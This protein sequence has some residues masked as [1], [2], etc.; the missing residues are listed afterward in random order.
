MS[1]D[2]ARKNVN[3]ER[4]AWS[5][6]TRRPE[7]GPYGASNVANAFALSLSEDILPRLRDRHTGESVSAQETKRQTTRRSE[8]FEWALAQSPIRVRTRE[9]PVTREASHPFEAN[10]AVPSDTAEPNGVLT[11]DTSSDRLAELRARDVERLLFALLRQ[12][13]LWHDTLD[14]LVRRWGSRSAI[15]DHILVPTAHLLGE[16]WCD[17]TASIV[18][19]TIGLE[20]LTRALDLLPNAAFDGRGAKALLVPT[21]GETHRFGLDILAESLRED[22]WACTVMPSGDVGRTTRMLHR[23]KPDVVGI[24]LSVPRMANGAITLIRAIHASVPDCVIVV[25]GSGA[26]EQSAALLEAG[27]TA[28]MDKPDHA[29]EWLTGVLENA[30]ETQSG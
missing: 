21:P 28:I 7:D 25:G 8:R 13:E 11:H 26:G 19:V 10:S 24:S 27:A 20:R 12:D 2:T 14:D 30:N 22:G 15:R 3:E 1:E 29:S 4:G 6:T 17:D 23:L 9:K 5:Q 16:K 18:D